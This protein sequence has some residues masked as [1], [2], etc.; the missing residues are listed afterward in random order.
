MIPAWV[1]PAAVLGAALVSAI[2]LIIVRKVKG[3]VTIQ[4]LWAENRQLRKDLNA[5]SA[6]VDTLVQVRDTERADSRT[7]GEGFDALAAYVDRDSEARGAAPL[8]TRIERAAID[9]A[10][11]VRDGDSAWNTA[12]LHAPEA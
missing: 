6:K 9:A 11:R 2:A 10:K 7:V 3:P 5:V 4:D 12:P 1:A 8:F